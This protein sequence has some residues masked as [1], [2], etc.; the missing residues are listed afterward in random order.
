[1]PWRNRAGA[2]IAAWQDYLPEVRVIVGTDDLSAGLT[3]SAETGTLGQYADYRTIYAVRWKDKPQ[4]VQ[5]AL[6]IAQRGI[7]CALAELF[8]VGP[9]E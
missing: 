9:N 4:S 7:A 6:E 3:I 2:H 5:E 1:M 8:G